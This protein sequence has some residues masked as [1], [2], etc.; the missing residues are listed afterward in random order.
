MVSLVI[1]ILSGAFTGSGIARQISFR[2]AP[3]TL[4]GGTAACRIRFLPPSF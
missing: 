4:L 2:V 3:G 1:G